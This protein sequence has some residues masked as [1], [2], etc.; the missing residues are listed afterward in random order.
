MLFTDNMMMPKHGVAPLRR[1]GAHELLLRARG[2]GQGGGLRQ[3]HHARCK[4]PRRSCA[5]TD[6]DIA[7]NPLIFPPDDVRA[8]LHA[9]PALSP[10]D[11]RTM[12]SAMADVTGA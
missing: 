8:R 1:R 10:T 9:Y 4:A 6:P 3:L 11:E 2:G 7:N 5:K 12:Q